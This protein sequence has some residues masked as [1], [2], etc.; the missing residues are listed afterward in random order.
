MHL[1]ESQLWNQLRDCIPVAVRA[2]RI[3]ERFEAGW[4]D[5]LWGA[6]ERAGFVELKTLPGLAVTPR[7]LLGVD[8]AQ[9][10]FLRDWSQ[11]RGRAGVL[12]QQTE[13]LRYFPAQPSVAWQKAIQGPG[14]WDRCPCFAYAF[15]AQGM[16]DF[17][18]E[19]TKLRSPLHP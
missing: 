8:P 4:P 12:A 5:I 3:T 19:L 14:A 16:R 15:D 1:T 18:A 9:A 7:T 6:D 11:H 2:R 13:S 10:L 17:F